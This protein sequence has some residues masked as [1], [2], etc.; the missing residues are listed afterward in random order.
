MFINYLKD[1]V[2][3][4]HAS[5][6][7]HLHELNASLMRSEPQNDLEIGSSF[8]DDRTYSKPLV[9]NTHYSI[10]HGRNFDYVCIFE[11]EIGVLNG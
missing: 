3:V 11:S 4:L 10:V 2:I 7:S 1:N 6:R 5:Y 9:Y 8:I